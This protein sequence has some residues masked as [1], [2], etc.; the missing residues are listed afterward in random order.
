[1]R[2][3][4]VA[5][6]GKIPSELN[7]RVAPAGALHHI[8]EAHEQM[9]LAALIVPEHLADK[10]PETMGLGIVESPQVIVAEI[11]EILAAMPSFQWESFETEVHPTAVIGEGAYI[12]PKDVRIGANTVIGQNAVILERSIIGENCKVGPLSVIGA[13]ALEKKAGCSPNRL[14]AQSGGVWMEDNTTVLSATTVVRATFGGF[15][16]ICE[17][18]VLDNL[19]HL[20]HDVQVG[21]RTTVVACSEVSGRVTLGEGSYIGPN[22]AISNGLTIGANATVTMG[23][24][25]VKDVPEN[26]RVTGNFALPHEKWIHFVKTFR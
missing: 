20:A 11:Q 24:T 25:G 12:A 6:A 23:S 16:R 14:L 8:E 5:F 15:T 22:S 17:G 21:K 26:T 10:V 4:D 1:M 19:I 2:D 18:A 3:A 7:A 13:E 9:G